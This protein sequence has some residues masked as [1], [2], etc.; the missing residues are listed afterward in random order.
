VTETIKLLQAFKYR[1]V[2][3]VFMNRLS[4][5]SSS[6]KTL[7]VNDGGTLPYVPALSGA[8]GKEWE[9]DLAPNA[10]CVCSRLDEC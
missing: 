6:G 8:G 1:I 7:A 4:E 9:A 10:S 3:G 5:I 2:Q